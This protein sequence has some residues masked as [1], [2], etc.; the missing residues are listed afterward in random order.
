LIQLTAKI[1]F[2]DRVNTHAN[3]N[4]LSFGLMREHLA[5]TGSKLFKESSTMTIAELANRM[6]LCQGAKEHL[7]PKNVGL[8]MFSEHTKKYFKG[9]QIDVV[10]FPNGLGA[11]EF[12]GQFKNS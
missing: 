1:P 6:N 5:K 11:K 12:E 2:D 8:L 9:V 3:I 4:D 7:F 10:E